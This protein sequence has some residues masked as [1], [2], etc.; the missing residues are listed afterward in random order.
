MTPAFET[1]EAYFSFL[2]RAF[3]WPKCSG[4]KAVKQ[5]PRINHREHSG[6]PSMDRNPSLR[7]EAKGTDGW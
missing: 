4:F 2:Y 1:I 5:W 6:L 7:F 3:G